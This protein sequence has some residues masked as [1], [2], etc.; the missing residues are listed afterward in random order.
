MRRLLAVLCILG[1]SGIC[2]AQASPGTNLAFVGTTPSVSGGPGIITIMVK[3]KS[4]GSSPTVACKGNVVVDGVVAKVFD[5]PALAALGPG[6]EKRFDFTIPGAAGS[7]TVEIRLDV[8]NRN[9]ESNETDNVRSRSVTVGPPPPPEPTPT[10]PP[11][12]IGVT[13]AGT[14]TGTVTDNQGMSCGADCSSS[15]TPGTIVSLR[16]VPSAGSTFRSWSNGTGSATGCN[17]S[18]SAVCGFRATQNSAIRANFE[19]TQ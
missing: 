10:P 5:I 8:D 7:H 17:N 2:E 6:D 9:S 16:A 15:V 13:K 19:L 11:V 18:T 4:I 1:F 3:V 12:R 14:G